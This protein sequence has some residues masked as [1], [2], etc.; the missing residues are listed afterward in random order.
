VKSIEGVDS[1][2]SQYTER[3]YTTIRSSY[4][5]PVIEGMR[6]VFESPQGTAYASRLP[7]IPM[8]GKTGTAENPHGQDHS[9]FVS[10][11]PVD[12]PQIAIAVIIE[13]GYWGSRWAA[14]I[15]SLLAEKHITDSISRPALYERMIQG[16]LSSEYE[17]QH[18][19][20]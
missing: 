3:R 12:N 20:P 4:F 5:N 19:R 1:I 15:A 13:N 9:I 10:F 11:A 7:G 8:A 18:Q 17:K 16:D 6:D 14:P 2:E